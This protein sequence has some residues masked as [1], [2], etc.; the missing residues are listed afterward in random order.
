MQMWKQAVRGTRPDLAK[1]ARIHHGLRGPVRG[2]FD[3][4]RSAAR[5]CFGLRP[6]TVDVPADRRKRAR[7]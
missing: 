7:L 3:E 2:S 5:H 4:R 1:L 6:I